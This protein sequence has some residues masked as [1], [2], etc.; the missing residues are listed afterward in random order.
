M[1]SRM[2]F[3]S[4]CLIGMLTAVG[5]LSHGAQTNPYHSQETMDA[6]G[7]PGEAILFNYNVAF[8]PAFMSLEIS[9]TPAFACVGVVAKPA[10]I[11]AKAVRTVFHRARDAVS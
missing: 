8:S 9:I 5:T 4:V 6:I 10:V 1:K 7:L 3:M 2:L 11:P